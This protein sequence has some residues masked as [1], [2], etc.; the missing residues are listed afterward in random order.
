M[1]SRRKKEERCV[2]TQSIAAHV[3]PSI[4]VLRSNGERSLPCA[5]DPFVR[6][7][8]WFS[9]H[10]A[11]AA[12]ATAGRDGRPSVRTVELAYL[13]R[14]FV[15]FTSYASREGTEL[16]LNPRA[17]LCFGWPLLGRQISAE[18]DTARVGDVESDEYFGTL[19]RPRQLSCWLCGEQEPPEPHA[20]AAALRRV[21]DRFANQEVPRPRTW[22]GFRLVADTVEFRER[23]RD[24]LDERMRYRRDNGGPW[25]VERI[26]P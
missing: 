13:A 18:G 20:L 25:Q 6:F 2:V 11:V 15:F 10:A 9:E 8:A 16:A 1:V 12:L 5:A 24:E 4:D 23:G 22:G 7:K 21:E 14:G 3:S 26:S 17:A 19:S